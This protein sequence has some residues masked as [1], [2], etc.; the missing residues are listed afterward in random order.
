M[1]WDA[2]KFKEREEA[3]YELEER[4]FHP[5]ECMWVKKI[6]DYCAL[7]EDVRELEESLRQQE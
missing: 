2:Q 7:D 1:G 5:D 3:L 4:V 6:E